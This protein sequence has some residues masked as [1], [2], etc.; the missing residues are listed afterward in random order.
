MPR[1]LSLSDQIVI[2]VPVDI[3]Y[4]RVSD[5]TAMGQWSPENTGGS[6]VG[7]HEIARVG[8]MFDGHNKRGRLVWTTR[9]EVIAAEPNVSFAFA[10][11]A[12]GF[13]RYRRRPPV[14]FFIPTTWSYRFEAVDEQSTRLTE[15]WTVGPWPAVLIML[16]QRMTADGL[17]VPEMQRR[18]LRITLQNI[19]NHLEADHQLART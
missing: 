3:V 15:T 12:A 7:S 4:S 13:G 5:V 18:N 9:C 6:V 10:V 17:N 8:T 19:K 11:R 14:P 2:D 1:T 16:F